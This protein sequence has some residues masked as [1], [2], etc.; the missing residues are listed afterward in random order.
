MWK[1]CQVWLVEGWT[2]Q[3]G[4]IGGNPMDTGSGKGSLII[5]SVINL[6]RKQKRTQ[7]INWHHFCASSC[8]LREFLNIGWYLSLSS[9]VKQCHQPPAWEFWPLLPTSSHFY[10]KHLADLKNTK[11]NGHLDHYQICWTTIFPK[12]RLLENP[13]MMWRT[14][15]LWTIFRREAFPHKRL[16]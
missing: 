12:I 1:Q 5:Q 2:N 3:M 15:H 6:C 11:W 7:P 13:G 14:H 4:D 9:R 10:A 8:F 16:V